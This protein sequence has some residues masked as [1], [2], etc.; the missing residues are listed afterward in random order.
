VHEADIMGLDTESTDLLLRAIA[1][2]RMEFLSWIDA[3]LARRRERE[4]GEGLAAEGTVAPPGSVHPGPR[5]GLHRGTWA[6]EDPMGRGMS[7]PSLGIGEGAPRAPEGF[8][9]RGPDASPSRPAA[10][11]PGTETHPRASAAPLNPRQRLD[12]LARLLDQRLKQ[13]EGAAGGRDR[14][15]PDGSSGHPDRRAGDRS[16]DAD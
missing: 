1:E 6:D 2:F 15:G 12:A 9:D 10:P 3:E 11:M 14:E 16:Q 5:G 8:A 4:P 7:I 13:A